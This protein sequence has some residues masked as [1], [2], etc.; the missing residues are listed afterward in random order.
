[1]HSDLGDRMGLPNV[2]FLVCAVARKDDAV[3]WGVNAHNPV[4]GLASASHC[5]LGACLARVSDLFLRDGERRLGKVA[6]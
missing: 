3:P 2:E 6:R 1:M 5:I 4:T